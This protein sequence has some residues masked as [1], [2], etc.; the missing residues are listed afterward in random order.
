VDLDLEVVEEVQTLLEE[1]VT[2]QLE[3]LAEL[4]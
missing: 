1:M 4:V 3:L 2:L